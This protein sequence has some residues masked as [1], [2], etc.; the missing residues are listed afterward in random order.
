M[1]FANVYEDA[2][3]AQAYAAIEFTGTYYLAYRDLPEIFQRH[4]SGRNALDFGCGAGRSTRFLKR[5]GFTAVGVDISLQMLE[6]ARAADPCGTYVQVGDGDLGGLEDGAF[7]L[8]L[9]AFTFDNI[10]TREAKIRALGELRRV[11]RP[12]GAV[13][14]V[15]S[16]PEI[17][18]HEW[19]SF[20]TKDFPENHHAQSGDRVRIVITDSADRRPVE[21]V[22]CSDEEYRGMFRASGLDMAAVYHPLGRPEDPAV[23]V[24]ETRVAPWAV[25]ALTGR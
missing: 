21:D 8:A 2:A 9:A 22:V 6:L 10:P 20:S 16:A 25:Y 13:V 24:T 3:C 15:V 14:V 7:D 4:A 23:W 5:H 18:G 19:A 12:G 11:S 17:Y 1:T